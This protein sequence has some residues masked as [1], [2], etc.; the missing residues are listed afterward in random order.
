MS[1][2]TAHPSAYRTLLTDRQTVLILLVT[3]GGMFGTVLAPA[4][5][6][7]ANALA[8]SDSRVGLLI[9][10]F[11]V[12]SILII[13]LAAVI[14]DT[15]GRRAVL[16]P[17]LVL[18]GIAGVAMA[19]VADFALLLAFAFVLG[20]G[21]AAIMPLTVTVL[22]DRYSGTASSTVQGL[23]VAAVGVGAVAVPALT[24][25]LSGLSYNY[26]FFLF[27]LVLP[28]AVLVFVSLD[29][30]ASL[31]TSTGDDSPSS[32]RA[33][34]RLRQYSGAIRLQFSD[35]DLGILVLGGFTRG[36][37]RFA[38]LTYVP[39]FAVRTLGASLFVA[40][41]LLS[42]RGLAYVT[43]SP[44]AGP[45][46]A[47]IGRKRS[48]SLSFLVCAGSLIAIPAAPNVVSVAGLVLAYTVGDALFDPVMKDS[49][50]ALADPEYRAGVVNGLYV[51]KRV[52]QTA[53]PATFGLVLAASSFTHLF[54]LAGTIA[55]W[56]VVLLWVF[57]MFDTE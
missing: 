16:V 33:L 53:S 5:P 46:V 26:P 23:R 49:V 40:G 28:L 8:V 7:I 17:S 18:F 42:V 6:G 31:R 39:L 41:L 25:Y 55:L 52:G 44:F 24:G 48:L 15:S 11:K 45:V 35:L 51:L 38:L 27:G 13:P 43:T 3:L 32:T 56:Y 19:F 9:S 2:E 36:F 1:D 4:L 12:P 21:G 14:A 47:R 30:T 22:G 29:E 54:V 57:F 20:V 10:F 34:D 37:V 50:T